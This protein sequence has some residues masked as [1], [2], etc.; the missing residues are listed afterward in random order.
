MERH[1][2]RIG[3]LLAG[4]VFIAVAIVG[5]TEVRVLDVAELAWVG[6][7]LLV[8]LGIALVVGTATRR[9]AT[10]PEAITAPSDAPTADVEFEPRAPAS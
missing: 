6:P 10:G 7:G 2:L 1:P 3:H 8:V 4:L 9:G 5:L